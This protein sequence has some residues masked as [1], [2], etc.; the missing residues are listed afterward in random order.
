M[1]LLDG[2]ERFIV[3]DVNLG[4]KVVA[5][6][7]GYGCGCIGGSGR[8]LRHVWGGRNGCSFPKDKTNK[9]CFYK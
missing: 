1:L 6:D 5:G 4:V 8:G 3:T 7:G 9:S 2:V